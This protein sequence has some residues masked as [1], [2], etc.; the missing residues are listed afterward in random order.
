M[1]NIAHFFEILSVSLGSLLEIP[2]SE[3]IVF[4]KDRK[5]LESCVLFTNNCFPEQFL[6]VDLEYS[7]GIL[8]DL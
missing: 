8:K 3:N 2:M 5:A 1:G 7:L 4:L 6:L